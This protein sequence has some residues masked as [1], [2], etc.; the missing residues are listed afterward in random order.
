M[1]GCPVTG[2]WDGLGG[3]GI[4]IVYARPEGHLEWHLRNGPN[5]GLPEYDFN[6]GSP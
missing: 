4:G 3:D 6:Y 2:N 1:N 5:P